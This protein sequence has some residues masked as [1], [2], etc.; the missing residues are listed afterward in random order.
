M[1]C[2]SDIGSGMGKEQEKEV[3]VE[4]IVCLLAAIKEII[5]PL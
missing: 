3:T 1:S 5:R 4:D 2:T